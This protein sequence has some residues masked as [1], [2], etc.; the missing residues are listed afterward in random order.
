MTKLAIQIFG[1]IFREVFRANEQRQAADGAR[2]THQ[3]VRPSP[4]KTFT[5]EEGKVT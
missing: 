3:E 5:K 1:L 4:A 2:G